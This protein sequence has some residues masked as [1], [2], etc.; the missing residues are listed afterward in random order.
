MQIFRIVKYK[1]SIQIK[2]IILLLVFSLNTVVVF[3]CTLGLDMGF[4]T[5]YHENA[6]AITDQYEEAAPPHHHHGDNGNRHQQSKGESDKKDNCCIDNGIIFEQLDKVVA[7]T[8][9]IH[10]NY[11]VFSALTPVFSLTDILSASHQTNHR[12]LVRWYFPQPPDIRVS[13]QSFQI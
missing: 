8:A 9:K 10:F 4:S 5:H 7:N 11:P 13:I 3:A 6:D 2:A 1:N 12:P